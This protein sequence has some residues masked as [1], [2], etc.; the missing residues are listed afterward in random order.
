MSDTRKEF[1]ENEIK[2]F[3]PEEKIGLVASIRPEGLPH[4][5]L[6][7]SIQ[8]AGPTT[9]TLGEFCK[10]NRKQYIQN[11]RNI[12]IL[13]M[14]LDRKRLESVEETN[15]LFPL[16]ELYLRERKELIDPERHAPAVQDASATRQKQG[17]LK[18]MWSFSPPAA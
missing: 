8:A 5:S 12:G 6:I 13:I 9:V 10:G 14:T 1:T 3:K 2:A 16:R 11:R 4:I 15:A 17:A 7:T 18:A